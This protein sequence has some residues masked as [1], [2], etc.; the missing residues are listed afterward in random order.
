SRGGER[1]PAEESA[2]A[3]S[4]AEAAIANGAEWEDEEDAMLYG[5]SSNTASS[6][7]GAA[8]AVKMDVDGA[9]DGLPAGAPQAHLLAVAHESG[10]LEIF[11]LP[12]C[13]RVAAF[14]QLTTTP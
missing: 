5:T 1:A 7:P 14:A 13:E 2:P 4:A 9:A 6:A 8:A 10:L 11:A 12:L 3:A